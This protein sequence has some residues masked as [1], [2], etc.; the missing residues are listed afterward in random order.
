MDE[1]GVLYTISN[2]EKLKAN[3]FLNIWLRKYK[4]LNSKNLKSFFDT[5]YL[6][7]PNEENIGGPFE[8]E[9]SEKQ[10][11]DSIT[12]EIDLRIR[13]VILSGFRGIPSHEIP[14]GLSFEDGD[15]PCNAVIFGNNGTGKSSVY[16]ALEYMF[17]QRIGEADYRGYEPKVRDRYPDYAKHDSINGES[18]C[19]C[20][21]QTISGDV[22]YGVDNLVENNILD[23]IA[24]NLCFISENDIYEMGKIKWNGSIEED[25][26]IHK[27]LAESLGLEPLVGF[28]RTLSAIIKYR[29]KAKESEL[30]THSDNISSLENE[31]NLHKNRLQELH[32]SNSGITLD[33]SRRISTAMQNMKLIEDFDRSVIEEV[34][35]L[36]DTIELN[37]DVLPSYNVTQADNMI[38]FLELGLELYINEDECP[39]CNKSEIPKDTITAMVNNRIRRMKDTNKIISSIYNKLDMMLS[40]IRNIYAYFGA[41]EQNLSSI[42]EEQITELSLLRDIDQQLLQI[43]QR[44]RELLDKYFS[45]S[46]NSLTIREVQST[47]RDIKIDY[48]DSM[49]TLVD[50]FASLLRKRNAIVNGYNAEKSD[51][52]NIAKV[53]QDNEIELTNKIKSFEERLAKIVHDMQEINNYLAFV[54]EVQVHSKEVK[55]VLDM[56]ISEK[57]VGL[58]EPI[59]ET[60][61]EVM[62]SYLVNDSL[63]IELFVPDL[64]EDNSNAGISIMLKYEQSEVRIDPSKYFKIGRAH[65]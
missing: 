53:N 42:S 18:S 25:D 55:R 46:I 17:T 15:K 36:L 54:I 48:Y 22:S 7:Y 39:F 47:V 34:K 56:R 2:D 10:T 65:V 45:I 29:A 11:S 33:Y 62:D 59:R 23:G 49:I 21:V 64:T 24:T 52:D 1:R 16:Q 63:C 30:K 44:N 31:I 38:R 37:I 51:I 35:T 6:F 32:V 3:K 20:K 50:Q 40:K 27:H 12:N 61:K 8:I 60:F 41:V 14:Y 5:L 57:L 9:Q 19:Q 28:S 26:S 13:N 58:V 43:I 4:E